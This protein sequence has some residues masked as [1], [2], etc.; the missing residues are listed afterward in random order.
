MSDI[1][2]EMFY[3]VPEAFLHQYILLPADMAI[4]AVN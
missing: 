3:K 1:I 4:A 2:K